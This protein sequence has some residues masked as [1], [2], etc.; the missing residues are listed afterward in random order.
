MAQNIGK[1]YINKFTMGLTHKKGTF[2]L[3]SEMIPSMKIANHPSAD[4]ALSVLN[5]QRNRSA[6]SGQ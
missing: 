2:F 5:V 1:R 6:R 3:F 4:P